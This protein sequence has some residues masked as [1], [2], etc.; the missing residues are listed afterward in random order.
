MM[1]I[2]ATK[3][4]SAAVSILFNYMLYAYL[5]RLDEVGCK[6]SDDVK[7]EAIK[8]MIL[9]NYVLVFGVLVFGKIPPSTAVLSSTMSFVFAVFT[10]TYLYRLKNKKCKCSDSM[11]RDVYYYYYLITFLLVAV[12][13]SM[14][15]LMTLSVL[16]STTANKVLSVVTTSS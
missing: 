15:V 1:K 10:F 8:A 11:V 7:K 5:D 12:V 13:V 4:F 6:C 14:F 9:V 16:L 3:I 2:G